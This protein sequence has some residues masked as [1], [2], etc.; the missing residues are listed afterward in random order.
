MLLNPLI[1][2]SEHFWNCHK[3]LVIWYRCVARNKFSFASSRGH[4][5][6]FNWSSCLD[7]SSDPLMVRA[8]WN[9]YVD[10]IIWCRHTRWRILFLAPDIPSTH[11]I[12][13]ISSGWYSCCISWLFKWWMFL[14]SLNLPHI[15]AHITSTQCIYV[16]D[17]ALLFFIYLCVDTCI[18]TNK[19]IITDHFYIYLD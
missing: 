17:L 1:L 15:L 11:H 10:K 5:V 19:D 3:F 7:C 18:D 13:K 9:W 14:G 6:T 4:S 2:L 16:G 12:F 8:I